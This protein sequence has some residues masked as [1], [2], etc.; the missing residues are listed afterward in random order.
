VHS[1]EKSR[2]T[3]RAQVAP[4]GNRARRVAVPP[5]VRRGR[6]VW[7][8]AVALT[9]MHALALLAFVPWLFSWTGLVAFIVGILVCGE[10]IILGYHRLLAHNSFAVPKWLEYTMAV[11]NMC[12]LQDTPVRWVTAHRAHHKYSDR[13]N[14]PHTPLA[15]WAW[16][17]ALWLMFPNSATRN[18]IAYRA[19][20][21]D[22]LADPVYRL[23]ERYPWLQGAIWLAHVYLYFAFGF[24]LGW[25]ETGTLAGG[26]QLG[27]SVVVWG[28]VLRTIAT[29]HITWSV[30]S[31][32]HLYGYRSYPTRDNSRN[33]WILAIIAS[34]EGWHHNHHHDPASAS[35]QHKWWELDPSFA[36]VWIWERIGL[37]RNV[38]RP[39]CRRHAERK[40]AA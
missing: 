35:N 37:A 20:A 33:N 13:E 25:I 18:P 26:L 8:Y 38:I 40:A 22:L 4:L 39:R 19:F 32:V 29:W 10:T 34:G 6:I 7:T 15:G 27:S 12:S 11:F 21:H 1:G 23:L 30:N 17:H 31:F 5:T 16:G 2:A 14:D 9:G 24:A 28:V 3:P 36:V